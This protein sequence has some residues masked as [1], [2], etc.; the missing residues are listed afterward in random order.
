M[1]KLNFLKFSP[2]YQK[3]MTL[4][5]KIS[6]ILHTKG[7]KPEL[8]EKIIATLGKMREIEPSTAVNIVQHEIASSIEKYATDL[9]IDTHLKPQ[10]IVLLGVNGSGKTT[11]AF[12]MAGVLETYN[13]KVTIASSDTI[14]PGASFQIEELREKTSIHALYNQSQINTAHFITEEYQNSLARGDDIFI[15][16]T[17]GVVIGN[18]STLTHIRQVM[19]KIYTQVPEHRVKK[20]FIIDA[21][22]GFDIERQVKF[23]Q[24]KIKIDG[25]FI[26][27][28]ELTTNIGAILFVARKLQIPIHGFGNGINV[29]D[30]HQVTPEIIANHIFNHSD[31]LAL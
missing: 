31:L 27:K 8:V 14:R 1:D 28:T 26:S 19:K 4:L 6:N 15:I 16:D 29:H 23:M 21:N 17:P 25:M 24:N 7:V 2:H 10:I 5:E 20:I 3:K 12:K 13:W 18:V 30:I 22:A 11:T 9:D